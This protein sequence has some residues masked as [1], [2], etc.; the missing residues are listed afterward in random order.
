MATAILLAVS[1]LAAIP[2]ATTSPADLAAY[3]AARAGLGRDADAHVRLALWCEAHGLEV[4]RLRHLAIAVATDPRNAMAR[5]LLGMV[6]YRGHW[7]QPETVSEK[8]RSDAALSA[9]LV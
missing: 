5:G 7:Q 2:E 6:A 9:A 3:E 8:V 1:L 4:E